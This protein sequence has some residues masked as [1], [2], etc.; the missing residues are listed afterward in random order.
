MKCPGQD[1]RY[2]KFDAI[3]EAPCPN[4]GSMVEFF[5][6]ETR[7]SCKSCGKKVLNPKMD[8]G[9]AAHCKFAEQCFGELPPELIREKEDLF[10]DRVAVEAKLYH[11]RD[12]KSIAHAAR[13]AR[14][15]EKIVMAEGGDPAIALSAAY[16]H[17]V[18]RGEGQE[19][20]EISTDENGCPNEVR[21]ILDKLDAEEGLMN[22]VCGII[23]AYNSGK[24]EDDINYRV[25]RDAVALAGL[26]EKSSKGLV[27]REEIEKVIETDLFTEE[28][29]QLARSALSEEPEQKAA[30]AGR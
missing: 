12:F 28:A 23:G 26:D 9:C 8:F 2:W 30:A 17:R 13:V 18:G 27:T 16:L 4:C 14:Y 1:P 7:R 10:K 20:V 29:R 19:G 21:E 5:K 6:D 15:A 3:F 24:P 11:K 22:E 25:F